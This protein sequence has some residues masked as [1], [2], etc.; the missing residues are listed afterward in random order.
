MVVAAV[1]VVVL[2]AVGQVSAFFD[3]ELV[4]IQEFHRLMCLLGLLAF[5]GNLPIRIAHCV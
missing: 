2:L 1:L 4:Q 3:F 5:G